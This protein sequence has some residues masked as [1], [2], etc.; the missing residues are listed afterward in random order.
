MSLSVVV[1]T[2][3]EKC[4]YADDWDITFNEFEV[5]DNSLSAGQ[6]ECL[7]VRG[8]AHIALHLHIRATATS[9]PST[10]R[11]TSLWNHVLLHRL[12]DAS[13]NLSSPKCN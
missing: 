8:S 2:I 12:I 9:P 3:P 6:C 4:C 1:N 7:Y 11:T 13:A 5:Q 10:C